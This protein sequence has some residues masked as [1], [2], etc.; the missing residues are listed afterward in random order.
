M[1]RHK[2]EHGRE[3]VFRTAPEKRAVELAGYAL[4]GQQPVER[5]GQVQ[6]PLILAV[7]EQQRTRAHGLR[8]MVF[9]VGPRC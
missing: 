7:L 8:E 2:H 4:I 5:L 9:H 6:V 3:L 1:I